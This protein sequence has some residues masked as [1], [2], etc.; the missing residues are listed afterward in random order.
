MNDECYSVRKKKCSTLAL[1]NHGYQRQ[2]RRKRDMWIE[3]DG[4]K[5]TG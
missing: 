4:W 1:Q 3:R 5:D 2:R